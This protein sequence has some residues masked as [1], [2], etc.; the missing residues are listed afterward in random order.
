MNR[1]K[2]GT[3]KS[4]CQRIKSII[5]YS[6]NYYKANGILTFMNFKLNCQ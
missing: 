2:I 4:E 6:Y 1:D 5:L 3:L